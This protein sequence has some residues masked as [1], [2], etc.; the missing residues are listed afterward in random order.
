MQEPTCGTLDLWSGFPV[1]LTIIDH[2]DPTD[3]PAADTLVVDDPEQLKALAGELRGRIIG[4][5]RER[6]WS[7]QQLARELELPKGTV[8]HH[9]KVLERAGLIRV[10]HTRKVRAMTEKFYGRVARLFLFQIDDP[11]RARAAGASTL[12]D[13]AFQLERAVPEKS[14]WGLVMSRL[15]QKDA[16]RFARRANRLLDDFRAA[17]SPDGDPYR[18]ALAYWA[19]GPPDEEP[20]A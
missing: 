19:V 15:A 2:W 1:C 10:V 12:R 11:E 3:Y 4:L 18:L 13:A 14:M 5:L 7:T 8:G 9:L 20:D 17:D 6:A 16:D